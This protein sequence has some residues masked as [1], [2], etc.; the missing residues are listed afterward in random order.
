MDA[1][2]SSLHVDI[3]NAIWLLWDCP[4]GKV[5]KK[6]VGIG[7]CQPFPLV[8][9]AY[10][11]RSWCRRHFGANCLRWLSTVGLWHIT[12]GVSY[13]RTGTYILY[14]LLL[15]ALVKVLNI[16]ENVVDESLNSCAHVLKQPVSNAALSL[17]NQRTGSMVRAR[18]LNIAMMSTMIDLI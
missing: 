7:E 4:L 10:V 9:D 13:V 11:L 16:P 12:R 18:H 3:D 15:P 14:H 8:A 6:I 1:P 17:V 5:M 2:K